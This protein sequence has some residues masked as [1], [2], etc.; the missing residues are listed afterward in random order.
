LGR[1]AYIDC[2]AGNSGDMITGALL[3]AGLEL[4]A[5]QTGLDKLGLDGYELQC[6]PVQKAGLH[7]LSF[8]NRE[9]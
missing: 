4:T 3:D 6:Q 8:R 2:F 7:A 9:L 1:I 5:L